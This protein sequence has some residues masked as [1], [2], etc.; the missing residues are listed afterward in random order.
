MEGRLPVSQPARITTPF[1]KST[2]A[3][4]IIAG[5]N[6]TWDVSMAMLRHAGWIG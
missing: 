5:L 6:L 1:D 3:A 4:E 2:T